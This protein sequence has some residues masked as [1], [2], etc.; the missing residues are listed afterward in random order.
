M[1]LV[2]SLFIQE[3]QLLVGVGDRA[4]DVDRGQQDEHVSLQNLDQDFEEVHS[5][6][7]GEGK[8]AEALHESFAFEEQVRSTCSR[9]GD[10]Q[11]AGQHRRKKTEAV[12]DGTNEE[13]RDDLDNDDQRKDGLRHSGWNRHD[14]EE[15]AT[16]TLEAKVDPVKVNNAG[17]SVG[18]SHVGGGWQLQERNGSEQVVNQDEEEEGHQDRDEAL[19]LALTDHVLCN[20]IANEGV[21][22]LSKELE[23]ARNELALFGGSNEEPSNQ[24][25]GDED[26]E[27]LLTETGSVLSSPRQD[28]WK[29]KILERGGVKH[30]VLGSRSRK[31]KRNQ[32]D[33]SRQCP[34]GHGTPPK[35]LRRSEIKFLGLRPW[36]RVATLRAFIAVHYC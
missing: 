18:G 20:A 26:E 23:L 35:K 14:L 15:L 32:R 22:R 4:L 5:H 24:C 12:G 17:Q 34:C 7:A 1:R 36:S 30:A 27:H 10:D 25:N 21:C 28:F 9:Q 11:V 13:V 29:V 6:T 2:V 33:S 16:V 8:Y 31:R 19:E 3:G